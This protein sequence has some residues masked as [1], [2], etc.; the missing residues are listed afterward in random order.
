MTR[1]VFIVKA[2]LILTMTAIAAPAIAHNLV[3][4]P[5]FDD[6]T[7]GWEGPGV[8]D[9]HDVDFSPTSGSSTF[10]NTSA[11]TAGFAFARQCITLDPADVGFDVSAWTYVASGQPA[12][13]YARVDLVWYT[14]TQCESFLTAHSLPQSSV[15]DAWERSVGRIFIPHTTQSVRVSA[16]NQKSEAGDFQAFFDAATLDSNQ[17]MIFGDSFETG[18]VDAWSAVTQGPS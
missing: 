2:V 15:F 14:D 10:V 18:S 16:I 9:A 13:G 1:S 3:V 11:G 4:N 17:T 7:M 12:A 5:N 8:Y 6:D